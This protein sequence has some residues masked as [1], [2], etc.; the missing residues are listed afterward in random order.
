MCL[1]VI[2]KLSTILILNIYLRLRLLPQTIPALLFPQV[3]QDFREA[4]GIQDHQ[5]LLLFP[6]DYQTQGGLG[7]PWALVDLASLPLDL[8]VQG[9]LVRRMDLAYQ[10]RQFHPLDQLNQVVL[11]AQV[12]RACLVVQIR[13]DPRDQ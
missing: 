6:A 9:L 2:L 12:V 11:Q 7:A 10:V 13:G 8:V 5:V 3:F 4:L 1:L